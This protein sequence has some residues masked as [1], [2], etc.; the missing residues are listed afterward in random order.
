MILAILDDDLSYLGLLS[1][2][3]ESKGHKVF[4]TSNPLEFKEI[5][6]HNHPEKIIVDIDL[7]LEISGLDVIRS[8]NFKGEILVISHIFNKQTIKLIT[9]MGCKYACKDREKDILEFIENPAPRDYLVQ[10]LASDE[11]KYQGL[12]EQEIEY[13]KH[14]LEGLKNKEIAERMHIA[15]NT[16][17]VHAYNIR[18]KLNLKNWLILNKKILIG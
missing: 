15:Y 8:L 7:G 9:R 4:T 13:V 11:P 10:M 1:E 14:K 6:F 12:T 2:K 18:K 5:I 3:A 16:A 17:T